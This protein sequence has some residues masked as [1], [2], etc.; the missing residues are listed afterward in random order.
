MTYQVRTEV[1]PM[2][3]FEGLIGFCVALII[4]G[5]PPLLMIYFDYWSEH[6]TL[7]AIVVGFSHLISTAHRTTAATNAQVLQ[8][9]SRLCDLKDQE[10][11]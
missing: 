4:I 9:E 7:I 5:G 10:S 8:L 6:A 2:I 3:F 11:H 1:N